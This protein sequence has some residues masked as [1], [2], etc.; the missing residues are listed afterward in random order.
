MAKRKVDSENRAFQN[1]WEAEYMFIDIAGKPVCLICGGNV[2]VIKEF[3]LRRHFETKHQD[4][5]KNLSVEQK[6]QKVEELKK[7]LTSQ[8]TFF[9]WAKSQ[10]EAAVK[11]SFIV[12]EEIAKSARPFTEGEFLKSCMMKVCDVLC[13]DNRQILANVSLSRNTVADRVCEMATDLRTQLMERSKD[14][15]AYCLAV[16]ESTDMTDTA[17]LAIFIRGVDSSLCITEE[18]LDIKSMHGTRTGK[19]IF[20]NVCQSVTDMKL[21]WDIFIFRWK[22]QIL[23]IF[24]EFFGPCSYFEFV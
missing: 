19:D 10:S 22:A 8:Q 20:E 14:F 17:Q 21:P 4:K 6:L 7:N 18:I 3:N 13:P 16:D 12:A 2:A 1:R 5:L 24:P 9:T 15:I 11:A 23:F